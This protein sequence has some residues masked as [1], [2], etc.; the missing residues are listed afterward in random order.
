MRRAVDVARDE[1]LREVGKRIVRRA[2]AER[3]STPSPTNSMLVKGWDA[4]AVDWTELPQRI[5]SW[6]PLHRESYA[7][8][9]IMSP[10]GVGSGGHQ[11][12]FRFIQFLEA[13]GHTATIYLY[14][15]AGPI[16]IDSVREMLATNPSFPD[17]QAPVVLLGDAGVAPGTDAIFA[18]GWET[19]YPAFLDRS[20]ARRLYFVQDFEPAF[21]PVGSEYV[22]AENTYRF[23]FHG[24]AAGAWLPQ[25]LASYGMDCDYFDFGA[26]T[27]L[28]RHV[29]DD[30]RNEVFF[31][32]RPVT[33]RRGFELGL[34]AL[35]RF[36]EERPDYL[37]NLAGWDVGAWDIA[38][39]HRNLSTLPI[40]ELTDVYNR[41]ATALVL[42]LTNMS[43]L[44]LELLACGVIPVLNDG[45]NNA[46]VARNDFIEYSPASPSAM[47]RKLIEVV[48]RVDLPERA[49]AASKSISTA[50]WSLGA[51]QFVSSFERA[52]R[53]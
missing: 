25:R 34:L 47:A 26:D 30:V 44:P 9:W 42:S 4:L 14:H 5:R 8:A 16:D 17:L 50:N 38:F 49:R 41:C 1:G 28:Y 35:Q 39:P 43:L 32:A 15:A 51:E 22:L 7:T 18:T 36:A 19:A 52:M 33:P 6:T 10:P 24:I 53:G 2:V 12:L 45:D 37:I 20:A 40:T 3:P 23:G 11:N 31:Y 29:N 21:Y 13:A 46:L 27:D 48:D